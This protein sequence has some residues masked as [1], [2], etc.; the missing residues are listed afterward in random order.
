M[1]TPV[2][3]WSAAA[4]L[5]GGVVLL[6]MLAG[7][8]MPWLFPELGKPTAEALPIGPWAMLFLLGYLALSMA[9]GAG[10]ALLAGAGVDARDRARW[11]REEEVRRQLREMEE[12]IREEQLSDDERERRRQS[13]AREAAIAREARRRL[14]FP[15][16]GP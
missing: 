12:A 11:A 10:V 16:T 2:I 3:Y 13:R 7:A 1:S 14:G 6:H 15:E 8:W 5:A 4:V 9:G